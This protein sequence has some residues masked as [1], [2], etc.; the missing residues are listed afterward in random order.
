MLQVSAISMFSMCALRGS[1]I[2]SIA[3]PLFCV[4]FKPRPQTWRRTQR[5]GGGATFGPFPNAQHSTWHRSSPSPDMSRRSCLL[6][7]PG[8]PEAMRA[9]HAGFRMAIRMASSKGPVM[10]CARA[11]RCGVRRRRPSS[12]RMAGDPVGRGSRPVTRAMQPSPHPL[13]CR[14]HQ[15]MWTTALAQ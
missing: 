9:L 15:S 13:A 1:T 4:K 7:P 11:H 5:E 8:G 12:G 6:Q 10:S 2:S 14:S 3:A